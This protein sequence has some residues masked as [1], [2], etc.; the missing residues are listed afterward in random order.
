MRGLALLSI[1]AFLLPLVVADPNCAPECGCYGYV[2]LGVIEVG[3]GSADAT[4]YV[5]DR[6]YALGNGMWFYQESNGVYDSAADGI[7]NLQRGGSSFLV[8]GDDEICDD[9]NPAGPDTL[10]Y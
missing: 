9:M 4:F 2:A 10:I 1:V 3:A 8:P 7:Y 6:N 5:D